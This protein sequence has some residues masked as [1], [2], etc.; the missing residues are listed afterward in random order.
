MGAGLESYGL[1][2]LRGSAATRYF[3]ERSVG[4]VRCFSCRCGVC[5]HDGEMIV[6]MGLYN[7]WNDCLEGATRRALQSLRGTRS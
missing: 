3:R 7:M 1:R 6:R 5:A 4:G 2:G